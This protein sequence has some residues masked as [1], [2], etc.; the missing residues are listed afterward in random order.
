MAYNIEY[1]WDKL[2][3]KIAQMASILTMLRAQLDTFF[4]ALEQMKNNA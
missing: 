3:P 2:E 4:T 1:D